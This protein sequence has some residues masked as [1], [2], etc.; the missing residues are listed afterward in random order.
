M[1]YFLGLVMV[2][3]ALATTASCTT[4]TGVQ[5]PATSPNGA[6]TTP[7]PA[8]PSTT[9][10]PS[11]PAAPA[12][13]TKPVTVPEQ[14]L[15]SVWAAW[16]ILKN[17]F[18]EKQRLDP[19]ALSQAA[20][21]D[22]VDYVKDP[23]L[24]VQTLPPPQAKPPRGM[25]KELKPVWDAWASIFENYHG[26][27]PL[28]P[29]KLGEEAAYAFV[30]AVNDP[31]T[32][33]IAPEQYSIDS[34]DFYGKYAGIG[35]EVQTQASRF[36]LNPMPGSPSEKAGL[37]PGDALLKIEDEVVNNW[38]TVQVVSRIRGSVGTAV[39]ITVQRL[40]VTAPLVLTITRETIKL[41]SVFWNMTN[42]QFA[43]IR[44]SSFYDNTPDAFNI[45]LKQA[46]DQGARGVIID[47]RNN[48]GGFLSTVVKMASQ[49]MDN[50]LVLYE[51]DSNGKRTDW[52]LQSGGMALKM[53]LVVLV[54]Q[55]SASGSE[56]LSGALQ[57]AKRAGVVGM[58]TF[59]KGSVNL[60][61]DLPDGG[62][63]YYTYARW[64][65][66]ITN[67]MIEGKGLDPDYQ[68][69]GSAGGRDGDAQLDKAIE[70]MKAK[71]GA[72]TP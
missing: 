55:Y 14:P 1:R 8:G 49:F 35:A 44:V 10:S 37:K 20:A 17:N 66:P 72:T 42:D 11:A 51:M 5:A 63:L 56:V 69:I 57:D 22:L 13:S 31:H 43:Y 59:G 15:S 52:K 34:Q 33:Y 71:V 36:L 28:D 70:L 9:A 24:T 25:P 58:T 29:K 45:M 6:A 21:A 38:T 26:A 19:Q 3:L 65:T 23:T 4:T 47:L 68:V 48:P 62:G 46:I 40:G 50:G 16:D 54:N 64:F 2:V 12:A 32:E 18:V 39:H 53:P 7:A 30:K 27:K 61:N 41:Q 60:F 67:R